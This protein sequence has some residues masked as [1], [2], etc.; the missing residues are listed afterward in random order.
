MLLYAI[1]FINLAFLLYTVG[2]WSEKIQGELKPWHL[3]V[4]W[5]GL[6]NDTIGTLSMEALVKQNAGNIAMHFN[7]HAVT[8]ML[9]I[10]LML[11]HAAWATIVIMR[12][13]TKMANGFHQFSLVV[14]LLW[15]VPFFTGAIS[16]V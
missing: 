3:I 4:F 5:L 8:G 11:F 15:L 9:A 6:V 1:V 2:V 16:H 10:I 12:K 13:D 7:V 14:W